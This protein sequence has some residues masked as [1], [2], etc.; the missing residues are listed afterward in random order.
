M[1]P[2]CDYEL[3]IWNR[4]GNEIFRQV[5]DGPPFVGENNYGNKVP[6]GVYFY[7]LRVGDE[8]Y[9]QTLTVSY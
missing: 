4:W 8:Y 2:L 7:T 3:I 1:T 5:N 6:A 9:R